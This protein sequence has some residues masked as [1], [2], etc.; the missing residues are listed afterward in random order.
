[1]DRG[2]KPEGS[3]PPLAEIFESLESSLLLYAQRMVRCEE[4]A[5]DLVQDAFMRLH[6]QREAVRF[7]KAW[8]E[9]TVHNLS[10]NHLRRAHREIRFPEEGQGKSLEDRE[11]VEP[12]PHELL[13]R[14]ET[15]DLVQKL[16]EGLEPRK[17][18]LL[19]LK[20]AE[21]LSY[22][23][24][25]LR[26]GMSTGNVGFQLHTLIKTLATRIKNNGGLQ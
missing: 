20:F 15:I 3:S 19:R 9:R 14:Q 24:I 26:T 4:T 2:T 21:R 12:Q 7:P 8:L 17:R 23:D 1:M 10:I 6:R 18:E 22:R 16:M 25:G 5:R 13:C 11:S